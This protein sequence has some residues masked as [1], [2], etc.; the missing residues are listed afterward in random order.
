[1]YT[2]ILGFCISLFVLLIW[3]ITREKNSENSNYG[4]ISLLALGVAGSLIYVYINP[5]PEQ[6][7]IKEYDDAI[8]DIKRLEK[9]I[10]QDS[11]RILKLEA[12]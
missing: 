12:K 8:S 1:M 2:L 9:R 6:P 4:I 11:V 3:I 10:A 5:Y 7:K